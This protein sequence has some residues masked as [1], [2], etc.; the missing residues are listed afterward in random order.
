MAYHLHMNGGTDHVKIPSLTFTKVILDIKVA[1]NTSAQRNYFDFRTGFS[2]GYLL[3]LTSGLDSEGNDS[4]MTTYIDGVGPKSNNTVMVP[5]NV[6]CL[7]ETRWASAGTD[8]GNIFGSNLGTSGQI[9]DI[10]NVKFYN[11]ASLVA[12]YD[13]TLGNVQDQTGNGNHATL[14]G[15]TWVDEGGGV[16]HPVSASASAVSTASANAIKGRVSSGSASV[17]TITAANAI[18]NRFV[19]GSAQLISSGSA[20]AEHSSGGSY[21]ASASATI[22]TSA[23]VAVIKKRY[24]SAAASLVTSATA[25]AVKGIRITATAV[26]TTTAQVI[27]GVLYGQSVAFNVQITRSMRFG[28]NIS[29]AVKLETDICRVKHFDTMI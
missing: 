2:F 20:T 18:K 10:W 6:R 22:S 3:S 1:R 13:M 4:P 24:A 19:S 7:L 5:D 28:A 12:H 16:D 29:K 26:L 14:N 17:V 11:G 15:G 21:N 27:Q 8:D 23:T 25:S 9:G